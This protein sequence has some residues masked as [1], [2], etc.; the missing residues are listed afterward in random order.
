MKMAL[1]DFFHGY[2][3]NPCLLQKKKN[4]NAEMYWGWGEVGI[5]CHPDRTTACVRCPVCTRLTLLTRVCA[6]LHRRNCMMRTAVFFLF[7]AGCL[8]VY[9]AVSS[10]DLPTGQPALAAAVADRLSY[11]Q[12]PALT[13]AWQASS[14]APGPS[15]PHSHGRGQTPFQ[16]LFDIP[17]KVIL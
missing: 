5:T 16:S 8:L 13:S 1:L 15:S 11:E 9:L 7:V 12:V 2:I 10:P 6:I 17:G 14:P 3:N 4:N